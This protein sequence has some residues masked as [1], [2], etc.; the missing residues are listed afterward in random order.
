M[1]ISKLTVQACTFTQSIEQKV[2]VMVIGEACI[3]ARRLVEDGKR[4][5]FGIRVVVHR[6]V[7]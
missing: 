1:V 4:L 6:L 5:V 3:T 2:M 7:F